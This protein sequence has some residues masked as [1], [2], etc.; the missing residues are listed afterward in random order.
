[1]NGKL[2]LNGE[3]GIRWCD[4]QRGGLPYHIND[5]GSNVSAVINDKPRFIREDYN[6]LKW[7]PAQVPG[8][9]HSTLMKEGLI[10]NPYEGA[11]ILKSRWVEEN[12]WNG[13]T[14]VQ[15]RVK[16]LR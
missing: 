8:E 15:L 10:E 11:N 4:G 7:I 3:W 14:K 1:L 2:N 6:Q 12:Y 13:Q 16:D 9:V 5:H